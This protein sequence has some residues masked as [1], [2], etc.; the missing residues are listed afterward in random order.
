VHKSEVGRELSSDE[1]VVKTVVVLGRD[2]RAVK[3]T[4]WVARVGVD[5]VAFQAGEVN[6]IF[7]ASRSP[8]GILTDDTG[9]RI[10][11]FEYLGEI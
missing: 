11:V 5:Y 6:M 8:L 3:F 4:A 7:L 2:D 9:R 10:R 1:L